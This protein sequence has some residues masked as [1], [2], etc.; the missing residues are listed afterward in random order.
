MLSNFPM[1]FC[2]GER[3]IKYTKTCNE[4]LLEENSK[5]NKHYVKERMVEGH[6]AYLQTLSH[7]ACRSTCKSDCSRGRFGLMARAMKQS[8]LR[9]AGERLHNPRAPHSQTAVTLAFRM[10]RAPPPL[11]SLGCPQ[12]SHH[13][14]AMLQSTSG[15]RARLTKCCASGSSA[16]ALYSSV[17]VSTNSCQPSQDIQE[18][19][20]KGKIAW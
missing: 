11:A 3:I 5:P 10:G 12:V 1:I 20:L 19:S 4:Q 8:M 15:K 18:S 9:I 7:N 14:G 13:A 6:A 2:T 16:E 17:Q